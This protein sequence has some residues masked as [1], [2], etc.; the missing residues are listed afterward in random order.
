MERAENQVLAGSDPRLFVRRLTD[1]FTGR[2]PAGGDVALTLDPAVQQA[3]MAGLEGKT[4]AVVALDPSTGAV[5]GLA[6]TPSYDPNQ[7][8][9]HEPAAIREYSEQMDAQE[10][11]P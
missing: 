9:S 7:L 8:S 4:G 11:D 3:A 5:L 1:L 2:D 6:S 10:I